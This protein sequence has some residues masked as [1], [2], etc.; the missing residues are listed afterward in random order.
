MGSVVGE[1]LTRSIELAIDKHLPVVIVSASGGA[2]MQEGILSLMQMAKTAAALERLGRAGLP[3]ISLLA[4]PTTGGVT[5]S[6]AMLGDVILAEPRALI[7]LRATGDRRDDPP[8][9]SPTASSARSSSW[10]TARLDLIVE[11]T[12]CAPRSAASS[13][14]SDLG[15]GAPLWPPIPPNARFSSSSHDVRRSVW[16][17]C[18]RCAAGRSRWMRPGLERIEG[19]LAALDHPEERYT[20]VQ[21]AAPTARARSR[22]CSRRSSKPMGAAGPLHLAPLCSFRGG[23]G[24][25]REP[26]APER[27]STAS[28]RWRSSRA[29][30]R[31]CSRPRPRSPSIISPARPSRSP[32][33]NRLGGRLDATTVAGRRRPCWDG[34]ISTTKAYLGRTLAEIAS[35]KAAIIAPASRS[36]P[37]RRR[38]RRTH[39]PPRRRGRASPSC[40]KAA[41]SRSPWSPSL[42]GQRSPARGL[43]IA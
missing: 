21:S 10:S 25:E 33:W 18:S 23:S 1:K 20:L 38:R 5:A 36:P 22:P 13:S 6:F 15:W 14:S 37:P 24:C 27:W 8:S 40:S 26:I 29:T 12:S 28:T 35:E 9:R 32:C 31:R 30:T 7:G 17:F 39:R 2:R 41:S 34:S 42:A 11:P 43:A 4:D 16:T 19:L 3:Y